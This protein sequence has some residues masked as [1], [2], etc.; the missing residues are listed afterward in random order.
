M[1]K[2][3]VPAP[4]WAK[5]AQEYFIRTTAFVTKLGLRPLCANDTPELGLPTISFYEKVARVERKLI[6]F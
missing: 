6:S 3:G 4:H 1:L 2:D 5:T